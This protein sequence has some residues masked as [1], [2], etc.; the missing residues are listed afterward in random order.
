M[1]QSDVHPNQERLQQLLC[2]NLESWKQSFA[3]STF[4]SCLLFYATQFFFSTVIKSA[5]QYSYRSAAS[6]FQ[7][8][9]EINWRCLNMNRRQQMSSLIK[10][11]F[12][13]TDFKQW[14]LRLLNFRSKHRVQLTQN[15][16]FCLKSLFCFHTIQIW[17]IFFSFQVF[18][19]CLFSLVII[20][21]EWTELGSG[22]KLT[23]RVSW[24]FRRRFL[25][26]DFGAEFCSP[27]SNLFLDLQ[28]N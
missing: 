13:P 21:M 1:Q 2:Q 20:T 22:R 9:E 15:M 17:P 25:C 19:I 16:Q 26:I 8:T 5:F 10:V 28:L 14:C 27:L 11:F 4:N 6:P 7:E 23:F 18:L 3:A 24:S 12:L